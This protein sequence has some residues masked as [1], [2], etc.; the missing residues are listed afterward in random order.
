MKFRQVYNKTLAET[1]C[2]AEHESGLKVIVIKKSGFKKSYATFSTKYGSINTMFVAPGESETTTV[3]D[4][5]A[6]FLE[7]KVFEQPDGTNAFNEFSKYGASANAFTSFG[8]TNYLFSCTEYFYENL[9][10]LLSFVQEPY[11]TQE[12]V[13][14]EKGIIAQEIRMYEDDAE[15]TC[16]Y[17]CLKGMYVNHPVKTNIAGSV[18]EI[19]KTTPE[20]LYKCYNTFYNPDNMALICVGDIDEERIGKIV[21]EL[22]PKE[23]RGGKIEQVFPQEPVQV[24]EKRITAEF[25]IPMP[26]FM[27]G[28]KDIE[29]GGSSGE[30]L[31]REILTNCALGVLFGKSSKFYKTL[32]DEGL[33]NKTF[34]A[35]YEYEE[36]CAYAAFSAETEKVDEVEKRI[37]D[38]LEE[39]KATGIDEK[40][41]ERAKR[42]LIGKFTALLDRVED[43]GNEYMFA[44]HRGMELLDYPAVCGSVTAEEVNK[45][46]KDLFDKERSSISIVLPKSK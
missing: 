14:K 43:L 28:F 36:S 15:Q 2:T 37:Y 23:N 25:D 5:V 18:E 3:I 11:F 10:I 27:L 19:M 13:E 6:H 35:F 34:S 20:L 16:F 21:D 31:K 32:Y 39:A 9:K 4:G 22:I 46:I 44:Y 30:M 45:R 24:N 29:T 38:C 41:L 40:E 17:N 12:N 42:V 8:V 33:I 1:V 26:M 7:H